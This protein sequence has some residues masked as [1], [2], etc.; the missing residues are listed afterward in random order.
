MR[1]LWGAYLNE[2][3][4][5]V[6]VAQ[7]IPKSLRRGRKNESR[8][9]GISFVGTKNREKHSDDATRTGTLSELDLLA[10]RGTFNCIERS[11]IV[12]IVLATIPDCVIGMGCV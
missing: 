11:N 7:F 12:L 6:G 2:K 9:S 5:S 4:K 3:L 1:L 10:H 8:A